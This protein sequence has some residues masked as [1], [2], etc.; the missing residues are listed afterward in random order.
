MPW[1]STYQALLDNTANEF[2]QAEVIT[3]KVE[4]KAEANAEAADHSAPT[5]QVAP[6]S[7]NPPASGPRDIHQHDQP[8]HFGQEGDYRNMKECQDYTASFLP[9]ATLLA[10]PLYCISQLALF[11]LLRPG[12]HRYTNGGAHAAMMHVVSCRNLLVI[13]Q[14]SATVTRAVHAM[15]PISRRHEI[16]TDL[17]RV[18]AATLRPDSDD[19]NE[20]S[21]APN[22]NALRD[23]IT[24]TC[25][26]CRMTLQDTATYYAHG[27][28]FGHYDEFMRINIQCATCGWKTIGRG[29]SEH[30]CGNAHRAKAT[31]LFIER[32]WLVPIQHVIVE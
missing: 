31:A 24:R 22:T 28:S 6:D 18:I 11:G 23:G 16:K 17:T 15:I 26:L 14:Q 29:V 4:I 30:L 2:S 20:L 9:D 12:T 13:G 25:R 32:G 10:D 21:A 3:M 8:G 5:P 1:V 27:C 7:I 19:Y